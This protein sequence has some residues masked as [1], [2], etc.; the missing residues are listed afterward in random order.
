MAPRIRRA[1]GGGGRPAA[2]CCF[3]LELGSNSRAGRNE[4]KPDET[5]EL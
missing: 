1:E 5:K 3:F 2:N 4:K